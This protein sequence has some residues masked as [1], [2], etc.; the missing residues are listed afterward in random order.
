MKGKILCPAGCQNPV[1][2]ITKAKEN[3]KNP[4]PAG[5]WRPFKCIFGERKKG[6]PQRAGTPVPFALCT[7]KPGQGQSAAYLEQDSTAVPKFA[8]R[9]FCPCGNLVGECLP[10]TLPCGLRRLKIPQNIFSD[11]SKTVPLHT[12]FFS[13]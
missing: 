8:Y 4:R 5:S 1:A 9:S 7:E 2:R 11:F 10:Q 3:L 6:R 12:L 13:Y